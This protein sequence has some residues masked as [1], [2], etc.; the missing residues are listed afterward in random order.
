MFARVS[1]RL[2]FIVL[3]AL[4]LVGCQPPQAELTTVHMQLAWL[5]T[6]EYSPFYVAAEDGLYAEQ[7]LS[8]EFANGGFDDSGTPIDELV[9]VLNGDA[10]F[11][12]TSSD[13]LLIARSQGE[14]L[15]A[16]A[17]LYQRSPIAWVTLADSGISKP[18]DFVG[19]RVF[20]QDFGT[21]AISYRAM[22]SALDIDRSQIEEVPMDDFS[23]D[24]ITSGRVDVAPAFVNN[25]PVQLRSA[26]YDVNIILAS[27]Y[28]IDVYPN[29]LIT[30]EDMIANHPDLVEKFLRATLAGIDAVIE[31]PDHAAE[32][33]VM[34]DDGLN[35][36]S[37]T[38][39]IAEALPLFK[40]AGTQVGSMTD[41]VWDFTLEMMVDQEL[42]PADTSVRDAY[43]TQFLETIH[44]D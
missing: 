42:V 2:F 33:T 44:A 34:Q 8:V 41:A 6:I 22:M 36:A 35:L 9:P 3:L 1:R 19:K 26:G 21:T 7:G 28:G 23:I 37:E 15:V 12:M 32:V 38:E 4:L 29:V 14:P 30:T 24:P 31:N 40:P 16:I 17:T 10:D 11:G 25:Q 27:D 39:S 20:V 5:P 18:Q 13:R 43:T